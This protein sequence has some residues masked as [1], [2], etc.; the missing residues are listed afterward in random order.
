MAQL[1]V[2]PE[3]GATRALPAHEVTVNWFPGF[4]QTVGVGA[5]DWHYVTIFFRAAGTARST[6]SLK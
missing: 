3:I 2:S 4:S 6:P 5:P 1:K